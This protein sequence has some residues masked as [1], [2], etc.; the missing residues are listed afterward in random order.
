M[1]RFKHFVIAATM[2]LLLSGAAFSQFPTA[3][4]L[5][6]WTVRPISRNHAESSTVRPVRVAKQNGY[7]RVVFEIDGPVPNYSVQYLK[8]FLLSGRG[9]G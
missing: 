3:G 4:E 2:G 7:D 9:R 1:R 8:G 5:N 6:I